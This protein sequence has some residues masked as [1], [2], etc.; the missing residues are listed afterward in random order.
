MT[1]TASRRRQRSQHLQYLHAADE[2]E[3]GLLDPL[4]STS[5]ASPPL[6]ASTRSQT[7]N[8]RPRTNFI[9]TTTTIP[10]PAHLSPPKIEESPAAPAASAVASLK[11]SLPSQ[12]VHYPNSIRLLVA[13]VPTGGGQQPAVFA[14]ESVAAGTTIVEFVGELIR[15]V[16]AHERERRYEREAV[17]CTMFKIDEDFVLDAS[18]RGNAA[19]FIRHSCQPN[20]EAIG[21]VVNGARKVLLRSIVPVERGDELTYDFKLT[22]GRFA[23]CRCGHAKC[24]RFL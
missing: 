14:D 2:D 18:R 9:V 6:A 19:R 11:D 7:A 1:S 23:R 10:P 13:H 16:V 20:C 21:M 12:R 4:P 8:K 3:F 15:T 5:F 24:R 22:P 17:S